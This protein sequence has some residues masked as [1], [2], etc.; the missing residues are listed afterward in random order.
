MV[1]AGFQP[2]I[3]SKFQATGRGIKTEGFPIEPSGVL[4]ASGTT[5]KNEG[6]G[7]GGGGGVTVREP[8]TVKQLTRKGNRATRKAPLQRKGDPV[9]GSSPGW[10]CTL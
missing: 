10:L 2:D 3:T 4:C 7:G 5:R 6:R 8:E 9:I 1:T